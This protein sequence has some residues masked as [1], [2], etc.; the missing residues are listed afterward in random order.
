MND[1]EKREFEEFQRYI[2]KWAWKKMHKLRK[3]FLQYAKI[4]YGEP[5]IV[6]SLNR[7]EFDDYMDFRLQKIAEEINQEGK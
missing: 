6:V 4:Y 2:K 5:V 3:K 7:A 1:E